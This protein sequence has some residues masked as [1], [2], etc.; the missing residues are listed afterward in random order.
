M[1]KTR[2]T[3]LMIGAGLLAGAG[4]VAQESA[5]QKPGIYLAAPGKAGEMTRLVGARPHVETRGIG[6]TML[7]QGFSKPSEYATLDGTGADIRTKETAPEFYFYFDAGS[8]Q[9]DPNNP[10]ASMSQMASMMSGDSLPPGAR[11]ASDFVLVKFTLAK[12]AREVEVGKAGSNSKSKSAIDCVIER[13]AQGAYKLHPKDPLKPGEY[14]FYYN[15]SQGG[16]ASS[17]LWD[18]GVDGK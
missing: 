8:S 18:F 7:T 16:G 14:A 6:K 17:P 15:S 9:P 11:T 13:L 5:K 3:L 2:L 12:D 10:A 1:R 4:V